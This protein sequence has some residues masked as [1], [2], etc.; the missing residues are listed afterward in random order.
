MALVVSVLPR[1]ASAS[2]ACLLL[3]RMHA[4]REGQREG[5]EGRR[6]WLQ[7]DGTLL[8]LGLETTLF[9]W[10]EGGGGRRREE[11]EREMEGVTQACVGARR[12]TDTRKLRCEL[13][14][15]P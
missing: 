11:R 15:R 12:D 8:A 6:G 14:P 9:S 10:R 5:E 13:N 2:C 7:A 4:R 3:A 1:H